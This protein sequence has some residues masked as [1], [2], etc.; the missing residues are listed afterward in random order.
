VNREQQTID[1]VPNFH[2]DADEPPPPLTR[3][4]VAAIEVRG[5]ERREH[6]DR[7]YAALRNDAQSCARAMRSSPLLDT[8]EAWTE[9]V[10]RS[11]DDYHS[12]RSLMEHLGADRLIDPAFTGMLLAIR[13]G[14][15]EEIRSPSMADYVLIDMAVIA[16]ANAMRVQ[17]MIGNTALI[18]EGEMF[19]QPTLRAKWKTEYGVRPEDIRGLAVEEYVV[20]LR[21]TLLPLVEKFNHSARDAIEGMR[22][23][24][25]LPSTQVERA[26]PWEIRLI[27]AERGCS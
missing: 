7:V 19:G 12:G 16:F 14:F 23:R 24:Q 4:E 26:A 8:T 27:P 5:R 2:A 17:S 10:D 18:M 3:E 20:Q 11:L 21:E 22:R 25:Q 9:L 15:L 6:S 1:P 13:R